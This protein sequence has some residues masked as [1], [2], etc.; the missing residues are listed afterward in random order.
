M[1]HG[2]LPEV[3]EN[4]LGCAG[5]ENWERPMLIY[6]DQ[7][8]SYV[9]SSSVPK[10]GCVLQFRESPGI[11]DPCSSKSSALCGLG[12]WGTAYVDLYRSK[13]KLG[14]LFI[15]AQVGVRTPVSR[16]SENPGPVFLGDGA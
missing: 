12:K 11:Q 13:A 2:G 8:K 10:S 15:R 5:W 1:D 16:K 3:I 7:K 9:I 14:D 4:S 6:I